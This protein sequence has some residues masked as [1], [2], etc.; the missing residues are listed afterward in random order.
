MCSSENMHRV[1]LK[2]KKKKKKLVGWTG[3]KIGKMTE[4]AVKIQ[5]AY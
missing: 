4:V 2:Q 1:I 3:V 5:S